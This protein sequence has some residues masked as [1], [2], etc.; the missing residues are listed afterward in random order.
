MPDPVDVYAD[1]FQVNTGPFG[2][3]L[4]FLLSGPTPPAPGTAPQ[5][6]RLATVRTSLEHLKVMTFMLHR[7]V[8]HYEAETGTDIP[9]PTQVL[10][11]LRIGLED[12]NLFWTRS[13]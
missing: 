1:Q 3:S 6:E 12:W 8:L 7:Q 11:A 10:N 5:V 9:I 2:C 4:N 13:R